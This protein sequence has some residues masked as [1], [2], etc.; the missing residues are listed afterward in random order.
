MPDQQYW[1]NRFDGDEDRVSE[2]FR[3]LQKKTT[4]A[5]KKNGTLG[6]TGWSDPDVQRKIRKK[7]WRNAK[8]R[9]KKADES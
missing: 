1:L 9:D 4:E 3:N 5:R 6:K 8:K 2:Y 7:G